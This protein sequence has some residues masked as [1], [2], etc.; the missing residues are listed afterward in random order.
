[1]LER[2]F[3]WNRVGFICIEASIVS[4]FNVLY[5]LQGDG[6]QVARKTYAI[7]AVFSNSMA[8]EN[9]L[10]GA[11]FS[12]SFCNFPCKSDGLAGGKR[13]LSS[14]LSPGMV[15]NRHSLAGGVGFESTNGGYVDRNRHAYPDGDDPNDTCEH[16]SKWF[17]KVTYHEEMV[18]D[19]DDD[20]EIDWASFGFTQEEVD[21]ISCVENGMISLQIDEGAGWHHITTINVQ[22]NR[23]LDEAERSYGKGFSSD[24]SGDG[25]KNGNKK[26]SVSKQIA[27]GITKDILTDLVGKTGSKILYS[28]GA[29]V[30]KKVRKDVGKKKLKAIKM[31]NI[32][33]MRNQRSAST[34]NILRLSPYTSNYMRCFVDPFNQACKGA[35]I[36]RPGSTPSFKSTG[37]IRGTGVIGIAGVG[38]VFLM[39]TLCN[40][41]AAGGYTTSAY[42]S[43][44]VAQFSNDVVIETNTGS[45]NSPASF[46][47]TNLPFSSAQLTSTTPG[48]VVEGRIVATSL[49]LYYTGTELNR[50]GQY[51]A[52]V[53]PD[54]DS[55]QGASHNNATAPSGGYTTAL[56]SAKDA[57]EISAVTGRNAPQV[58]WLAT[59]TNLND[60]PPENASNLRKL[61]PYAQGQTQVDGNHAVASG[62]IMITGVAGQPFYFEA[63]IHAEYIGAGVAQSLLTESYSDVVGF[64]AIQCALAR[65]QR[66]AANDP[67]TNLRGCI[68]TELKREG[69]VTSK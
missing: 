21:D 45:A 56:L 54:L 31:L 19:S 33:E 52:Y 39:P 34:G 53:D 57:C 51:F 49:K 60:Y 28:S 23:L 38:Y 43:T 10:Q 40:D 66:S 2:G 59:Q 11:N 9:L 30:V 17:R 8:G 41:F 5:L 37:Y 13:S 26:Q 12:Q 25:P 36:P 55:V 22:T 15:S 35:G 6:V 67:R 16:R 42:S 1:M 14:D 3:C 62:V 47:M 7:L 64:D 69:I 29:K 18:F 46:V 32:P 27:R 4:G 68:S 50:S 61:Y 63:V 44:Q 58:I 20:P 48:T 65:A 24:N